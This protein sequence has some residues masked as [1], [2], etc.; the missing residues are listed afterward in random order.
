M[1]AC[2]IWFIF[3]SY[4]IMVCKINIPLKFTAVLKAFFD[5]MNEKVTNKENTISY[6][7]QC[8]YICNNK[9]ISA[10]YEQWDQ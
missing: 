10:L 7:L 9:F 6:P 5:I 4:T 1:A 8:N 2:R 3:L